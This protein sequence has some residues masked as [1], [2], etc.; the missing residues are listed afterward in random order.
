MARCQLRSVT[1][2]A[3]STVWSRMT[4]SSFS[5][6]WAYSGTRPAGRCGPLGSGRHPRHGLSS[7][8]A[9][10]GICPDS[11]VRVCA[12]ICSVVGAG[13]ELWSGA[14]RSRRRTCPSSPIR[15]SARR[16]LRSIAAASAVR[17]AK[18]VPAVPSASNRRQA[19]LPGRLR[20]G[21]Q[22]ADNIPH[23]PSGRAAPVSCRGPGRDPGCL[24][25]TNGAGP[26]SRPPSP[27]DAPAPTWP[28]LY[29]LNTTVPGASGAMNK[30]NKK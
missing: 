9:P 17:S 16:P 21:P 8:V 30:R 24:D 14:R 22:L 3:Y 20:A 29:S 4:P 18:T 1:D 25:P 2:L 27:A 6:T 7:Q 23:P 13:H 10:G 11:R 26:S 5:T 12:A 15:N 28:S 19:L